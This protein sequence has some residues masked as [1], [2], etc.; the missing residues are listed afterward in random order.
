MVYPQ[1][2]HMTNSPTISVICPV[3]NREAW[4]SDTIESV[5]AQDFE[6]FELILVDDG[7]S[8]SSVD[9][10]KK[11]QQRYPQKIVVLTQNNKGV[12]SARNLGMKRAR[13]VFFAFIDSDDLW[14]SS[15][16]SKQSEAMLFHGWPISQTDERWIRNGKRVNAMKK[17]AKRGGHIFFDCLPLCMVSPSAVMIHRSVFEA[18]GNFDERLRV[19]EDY[20]LWLRISARYTIGFVPEVLVVKHGGHEDQLSRQYPIMDRYRVYALRKLLRQ[21]M[22]YLDSFKINA[23]YW[24]IFTKAKII[25]NG[26]LKRGNFVLAGV[27]FVLFGLYRLKWVLA[28]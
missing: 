3:Y 18:V 5:M 19:V 8:D 15:K 6:S 13:G 1:A 11:Y 12:S 9:I 26:A 17:H 4:L 25:A 2:V 28:R 21:S 14:I 27:Y 10:M 20:D 24:W 23:V 7:S 22:R 16:L